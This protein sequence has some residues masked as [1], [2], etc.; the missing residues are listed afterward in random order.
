MCCRAS[1]VWAR[2][3]QSSTSSSS[4]MS[5]SKMIV[6]A[7]TVHTETDV[8]VI[9]QVLFCITKHC[10]DKN[11]EQARGQDVPQ[12]DAIRNGEAAWQWPVVHH[13]TLL[14]CWRRI[15]RNWGGQPRQ[16][17]IF[18]SPSWLTVSKALVRST[19]AAYRTKFCSVHFYCI[20]LS[21]KIMSAVPLLN[22]N[23]HWLSSVFFC[24]VIGMSYSAKREPRFCLQR[25][26]GW[27]LGS[28][29]CN[30]HLNTK[31]SGAE[32]ERGLGREKDHRGVARKEI[33]QRC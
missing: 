12:L 6:C 4:V 23:L 7:H 24:A 28:N 2:R 14:T 16:S 32:W 27:Y 25:R 5:S 13:L 1:S 19:K 15:V 22:V 21:T 29:M 3:A 33:A 11:V 20:C 30:L 31:S 10:T 17:R 18:H 26:V 9:W 8:D